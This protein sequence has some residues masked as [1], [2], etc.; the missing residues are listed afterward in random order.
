MNFLLQKQVEL[1]ISLMAH[2]LIES[3]YVSIG[4]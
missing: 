2:D 1:K 4:E 3:G